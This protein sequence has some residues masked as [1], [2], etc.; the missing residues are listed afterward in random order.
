MNRRSFI[1]KALGA[2]AAIATASLVSAESVERLGKKGYDG[3]K[4]PSDYMFFSYRR[5]D[6]STNTEVLRADASG[7][8]TLP[9]HL[10]NVDGTMWWNYPGEQ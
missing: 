2:V 9:A 8:Y 1:S 4:H 5:A 3:P 6:G 10:Q 7:A